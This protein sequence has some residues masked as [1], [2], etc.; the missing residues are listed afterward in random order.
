MT[1]AILAADARTPARTRTTP[2]PIPFTRILGVELRKMF[3]TRS[4]FWLMASIG[5]LAVIATGA[6]ILFAP[7]DEVD[8]SAF[9]SAIGIPMTIILPM[10]AVLSVSSEW[11]Q[12]SALTTFTLVP[13]RAR[14]IGAK[15]LLTVAVGVV[16]MLVALG[17]GAVGNVIGSALAGVDQSWNVS[18]TEFAQIVLADGIGMLMGFMLGVLLRNSPAAIVGYFVYALV[19]PGISGA[20]ASA[21]DWWDQHGAWFD[22]NW[23]SNRLYDNSL[24][25]EMWAQLGVTTL[26]WLVLPLAIGLRFLMR[27][28]VK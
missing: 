9:A 19:L 24:T 14:V 21:N 28:E 11:S 10:I 17:V 15:A 27:A 12:R 4:G 3:D 22:L 16:S 7:S 18:P 5:I 6:V 8:Y 2:N 23:A 26:L 1:T 25:G 13:S 20:L